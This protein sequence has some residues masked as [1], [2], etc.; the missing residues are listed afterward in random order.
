MAEIEQQA[1]KPK[2]AT[3][4]GNAK[5]IAGLKNQLVGIEG[6]LKTLVDR[7]SESGRTDRAESGS[8]GPVSNVHDS[9]TP[10]DSRPQHQ[11]ERP[12]TRSRAR[13]V[14]VS[15]SSRRPR[16]R[17]HTPERVQ[18]WNEGRELH[19]TVLDMNEDAE[20]QR[21][22]SQLLCQNL[23]PVSHASSGKRYFAYAHVVRGRKKV[24]TGL[25]ELSLPEYNFGLMQ[26]M[27]YNEGEVRQAIAQHL[28]DINEDA[29]SYQW[30]DVRGWSEE[31]CTRINENRLNWLDSNRIEYLRLKLSQVY[32]GERSAVD[33]EG[34]G[35]AMDMEVAAAKPG[36]PCRQYN[37]SNCF[38]SDDHVVNGYRHLH[39]CSFCIY[40]KCM[41]LKHA[42][43]ECKGKRFKTENKKKGNGQGN[44]QRSGGAQ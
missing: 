43:R 44:E 20:L 36:P 28:E 4:A 9:P 35:Y 2:R 39:V 16:G 8:I 29:I 3:A 40:N 11:E 18:R 13:S 33:C 21:R 26:M 12:G 41:F 24:K 23:N 42:E 7:Q 15:R 5:E 1:E 14:V 31:V 32:R 25:G 38:S 19:D 30:P 22:V 17:S 37:F 27:K 34:E 6:M 10:G